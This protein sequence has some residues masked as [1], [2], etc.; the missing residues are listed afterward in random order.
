[1]NTANTLGIIK[2]VMSSG[3]TIP[4][5]TVTSGPIVTSTPHTNYR[6]TESHKRGIAKMMEY[7]DS[8]HNFCKKFEVHIGVLPDGSPQLLTLEGSAIVKHLGGV[9][10]FEVYGEDGRDILNGIRECYS[11]LHYQLQKGFPIGS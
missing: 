7:F 1:M 2:K 11:S 8:L 9:L 10:E 4:I 3:N 6:L 5:V